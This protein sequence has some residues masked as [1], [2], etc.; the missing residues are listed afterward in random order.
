VRAL[1]G[2]VSSIKSDIINLMKE[3]ILK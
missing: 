3:K 1:Q 2:E